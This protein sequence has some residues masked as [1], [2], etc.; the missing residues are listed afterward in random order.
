MY[1][2]TCAVQTLVVQGSPVN[3]HSSLFQYK[4]LVPHLPVCVFLAIEEKV[5]YTEL[6]RDEQEFEL[7]REP[8]FG[9]KGECRLPLFSGKQGGFKHMV[10][11]LLD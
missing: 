11:H 2:W 8:I 4:T 7:W 1:N 10:L 3:C 9:I 6:R 5:E